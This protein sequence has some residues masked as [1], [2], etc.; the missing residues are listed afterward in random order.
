MSTLSNMVLCG[1]FPERRKNDY[2]QEFTKPIQQLLLSVTPLQRRKFRR[3]DFVPVPVLAAMWHLKWL[4][5][6]NAPK[7]GMKILDL[8]DSLLDEDGQVKKNTE[9]LFETV[10][11]EDIIGRRPVVRKQ[12]FP[13]VTIK[14]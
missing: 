1:S 2:L 8:T 12:R 13:V 3:Y 14:Y 5:G 7:Q 10:V 6:K 11:K 9:W 4:P